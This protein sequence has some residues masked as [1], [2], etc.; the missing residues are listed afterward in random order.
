MAFTPDIQVLIDA[1]DKL[2]DAQRVAFSEVI[3]TDL[4]QGSSITKYHNIQA[5]ITPNS[6][7]PYGNRGESWDFMKDAS[8]LASACDPLP[9]NVEATFSAKKWNPNPYYCTLEYCVPDLDYKMKDFFNSERW[10]DST[11][12][13][14]FYN[15]FLRDLIEQKITNSH[16]TKTYFGNKGSANNALTGVDG[17]FIQYAAVTGAGDGPQ[18]VVITENSG[19]NYAAQSLGADTGLRTFEAM[20][21]KM[22]DSRELRDKTGMKIKTTRALALNYLRWLRENKQVSCCERDP[23][24]GTYNLNSLTMFGTPIEV[25]DE[26]DMIITAKD[27]ITSAPVFAELNDGTRYVNPHRAVIT[28]KENEPIGTGDASRLTDLD[29]AHD[30]YNKKVKFDARYTFDVK[31]IRDEHFILAM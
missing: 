25:V 2:S 3:F 21:Q 7:I 31:L 9:C 18:R 12:E 27:D 11:D 5:G 17:L 15:A 14:T 20:V 24:T 19:A 29:F 1:V 4:K 26:W 16:W 30:S 22:E 10:L 23:L 28:Y 8:G 6:P 13:G